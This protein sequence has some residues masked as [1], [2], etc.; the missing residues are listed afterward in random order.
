MTTHRNRRTL[1]TTLLAAALAVALAAPTSVMLYAGT[2]GGTQAATARVASPAA[3]TATTPSL[4]EFDI[5]PH[6]RGV[7]AD[8]MFAGVPADR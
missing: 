6:W 1:I 4:T 8:V 7:E 3:M 2:G 5:A